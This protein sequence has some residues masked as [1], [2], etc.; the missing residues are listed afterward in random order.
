M[1]NFEI[2]DNLIHID[3]NVPH[4]AVDYILYKF[5]NYYD[6]NGLVDVRLSSDNAVMN[7]KVE[8]VWNLSMKHPTLEEI[9][10]QFETW[11]EIWKGGVRCAIEAANES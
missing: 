11:Y 5:D 4:E 3:D 2:K 6:A 8:I 1:K 7:R 10:K 9:V